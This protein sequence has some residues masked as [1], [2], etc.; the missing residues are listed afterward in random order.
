MK[1]DPAFRERLWDRYLRNRDPETRRELVLAYLPLVKYLAAR[2]KVRP[3]TGLTQEDLEA[4]GVVGLLEALERYDRGRGAGFETFARRRIQG[5]MLDALRRQQWVPRSVRERLQQ[6]GSAVRALE[7]EK[8]EAVTDEQLA[9]Y[10]G[11]SV[12]E[13]QEVWLEAHEAALTSLEEVLFSGEG[14]PPARPVADPESPDP[15]KAYEEKELRA[16]LAR[17]LTELGE[18]DRLVLS[19]YYYEGLT[20]KE[21]G[22]VLG[23][24]ESR[25]CQLRGRALVRLRARIKEWGY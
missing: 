13:V 2:L 18:T 21:I 25:A 9:A 7:Q 10:L 14:E 19:L 20:L 4:Y 22:Q 24:S 12:A 11:W 6:V 16:L 3:Q 1:T 8:G 17:A 5:A 15:V 23:V